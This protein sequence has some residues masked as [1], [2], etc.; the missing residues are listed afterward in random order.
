MKNKYLK[1]IEDLEEKRLYAFSGRNAVEYMTL[2]NK[3]G[4]EPED[5]DLYNQGHAEW[6][7]QKEKKSDLEE[8]LKMTNE[9]NFINESEYVN[10]QDWSVDTD[11][12]KE[13]MEKY[14]P[15][16]F[17]SGEVQD[18]EIEIRKDIKKY[19]PGEIGKIFDSLVGFYKK[20]LEEN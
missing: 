9:L 11:I 3:L 6:M 2:C 17:G 13:L 7:I 1:E 16:R 8:K 5:S 18:L 10:Y 15:E 19:G 14:F 20:R 12:K 4:L